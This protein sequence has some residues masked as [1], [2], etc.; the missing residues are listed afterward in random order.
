MMDFMAV[1]TPTLGYFIELENSKLV[2]KTGIFV[3]LVIPPLFFSVVVFSLGCYPR[4]PKEVKPTLRHPCSVPRK[5][6][7]HV[8][9]SYRWVLQLTNTNPP[10]CGLL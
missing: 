3:F 8:K 5:F 7:V 6:V 10:M 2:D 4:I 9:P 1:I